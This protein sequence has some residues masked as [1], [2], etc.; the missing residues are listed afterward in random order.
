[1]VLICEKCRRIIMEDVCPVCGST[2][3]R[4]PADDDHAFL[5]TTS[6]AASAAVISELLNQKSIPFRMNTISI[7]KYSVTRDF[8]VPYS[9]LEEAEI[10]VGKLWKEEQ[11]AGDAWSEG[12]GSDVF[13]ADEIDQMEWSVLDGMDLEEL[14]A[15]KN[16]ISKTLKEIKT[17]EQL[18]KERTNRLLDMRE[19]AENLIDELS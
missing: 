18:W 6:D 4:E 13:Q 11:P 19:E 17:Q 9:R 2:Q 3:T 5:I 15:Y 10:E 16:K 7:G 8:Y 1:M 14:K 12:F